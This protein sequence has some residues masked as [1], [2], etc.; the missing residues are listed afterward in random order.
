MRMTLRQISKLSRHI[1][2]LS[3]IGVLFLSSSVAADRI[4]SP[5][6]IINGNLGGSFGGQLSS[7]SYAMSAIGGEAV[8]GNGASGSYIID[9]QNNSAPNTASMSLA[10]QPSGLVGYYPMDENTGT[11]TADA[12][13]NSNNGS[14]V[15][16]PT[17]T[18]GKI[19]SAL[20]FNGSNGQSVSVAN[21]PAF[22]TGSQMTLSVWANQST[23]TVSKALASHWDYVNGS[24][25]G[26]WALQVSGDSASRLQFFVA[27]SQTDTGNN[28]FE[29][30][31]GTWAVG[32]WHHIVV[33]YDGTQATASNRVKIYIDGVST[34]ATMVGTVPSATQNSTAPL[35]IGDFNGL[36]RTWNGALDQVKLFS[37]S[38]SGAEVSAEYAAQNAGVA[39]GLTLGTITGGSTTSLVDAIV[40]TNVPSY[41]LSVQE[42]HDLQSG[43]NTIPAISGSIA[44]PSTWNEGVT[45]GLGFTLTGAPTLDSKW[46]SGASYAAV[47]SSATTFYSSTGHVNGAVDVVNLRLR[48][49]TSAAQSAGAYGNSITYTGTTIP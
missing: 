2:G 16:G 4:S 7:A 15:S 49:D 14:L 22:N 47:P 44:S 43:A 36:N 28:Y 35:M 5:N 45:K 46:S 39:T 17:W 48:L 26:S 25:S 20:S 24:H 34:A 30:D 40:R 6:Y 18:A 31:A 11:S 29:T 1:A 3:F 33:V 37:R 8:V 21:S 19:G 13:S 38:L 32:G 9:Q 41:N 42:D 12:S 10:V 27:D 23:A